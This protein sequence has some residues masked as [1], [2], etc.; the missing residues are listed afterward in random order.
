MDTLI[1]LQVLADIQDHLRSLRVQN[2]QN[3]ALCSLQPVRS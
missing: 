1:E 3:F 2:V